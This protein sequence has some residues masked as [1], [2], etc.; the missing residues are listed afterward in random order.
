MEEKVKYKKKQQDKL[1]YLTRESAER[2]LDY[3]LNK[4]VKT[5]NSIS[6]SEV[7]MP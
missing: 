7:I 4:R 2:S 1:R 5:P 3:P 6:I